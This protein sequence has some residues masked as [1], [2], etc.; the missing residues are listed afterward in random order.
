VA[1]STGTADEALPLF[2]KVT[3]FVPNT[4]I[5]LTGLAAGTTLTSGTSLDARGWRINI[6]DLPNARV[7][8]PQGYSGPM[9]LFA[10]LRDVEGRPLSRAPVHL[11]W[12]AAEVASAN[13]ENNEA[14]AGELPV[15]TVASAGD[16]QNQL[17]IV[18]P[19]DRPGEKIVLPKPRPIKHASFA[20][21]SGKSKKQMAVAQANKHRMPRRDPNIGAGTRW[22]SG[23]S[24][25]YSLLAD[26]RSERQAT[27]EQ[28]FRNVFDNGTHAGNCVSARSTQ[29]SQRQL[30]NSCNQGR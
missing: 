5:I 15:N 6:S 22:A 1:D 19:V 4:E 26:P 10:E 30:E 25:P 2:V 8:P 14:A 13:G 7:V 18:Q 11:T 28:I 9:T 17:S 27:L 23:E 20:P 16:A 3:N 29:N 21:K 12:N 24:A